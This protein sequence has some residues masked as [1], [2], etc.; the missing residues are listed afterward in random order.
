MCFNRLQ[1]AVHGGITAAAL[2]VMAVACC[3]VHAARISAGQLTFQIDRRTGV[4]TLQSQSPAMAFQ[5]KVGAAVS[6]VKTSSGHDRI[7]FYQRIAFQWRQKK[8]LVFRASVRLYR[9]QPVALFSMRFL[10]ATDH[11]QFA[12]PN[13]SSVPKAMHVFSYG[14]HYFSPPQFRAGQSGT[15][16]LLFDEHLNAAIISPASHFL[17]TTMRGDG[18]KRIAVRLHRGIAA[19]PRGYRISSLMVIT[20]GINPAWNIWG[21][22]LTDLTGKI[23][24]SNEADW[25]LRYLGYWT[26][27]GC[28][29]FLH[30]NPKLGYADTL[31]DEIRYLHLRNIPTHYLQLDGWWGSADSGVN[32]TYF[33]HGLRAFQKQLGIPLFTYGVLYGNNVRGKQYQQQWNTWTT[34]LKS[35]GAVAYEADWLNAVY[36][37]QHLDS[38]LHRGNRFFNSMANTMAAFHLPVMYSMAKPCEFLQAAKY[39]NVTTAR[40]SNDFFIQPRWRE[41]VFTSRL[42]GALGIWP[43]T[44]ACLSSSHYGMLLQ[45]L[46]AGMVGFGDLRGHENRAH[47]M[48]AVRADGVIVKP[49]VPLVPTGQSYLN[50]IAHPRRPIIARTYTQQHG[51]RTVYVFAFNGVDAAPATATSIPMRIGVQGTTDVGPGAYFIPTTPCSKT[52]ANYHRTVKFSPSQMG[53]HGVVY[54]YNYFTHQVVR[55]PARGA[56]TGRLGKQRASFYVCAPAG[57]SG[58]AFLG[59]LHQYV[60]TGKARIPYLAN[61]AGGLTA[62]VAFASGEQAI[63]LGGYAKFKPVVKMRGGTASEVRYMPTTGAWRVTITLAAGAKSTRLDGQPVREVSVRFSRP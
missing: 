7:G 22:A 29:Y 63:T 36:K 48:P 60:G 12:F 62:T 33:P 13:F 30:F 21:Q 11:P 28:G 51:V 19:V 53:L 27:N 32:R 43:W 8:N 45:T 18:M 54:V 55:V 34:Y 6:G 14:N 17:I 1:R 46:S 31:L 25:A 37:Q 10:Q 39:S 3:P 16:W 42:A 20:H 56:F 61:T 35:R 44:D 58:I 52:L 15:P 38:H 40:V 26:D 47:I 24:P 57:P 5:G 2:L 41:F 59:D 23:R 50:Q 49:D 4:Y 9:H